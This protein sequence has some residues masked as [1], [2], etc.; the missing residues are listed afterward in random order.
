MMAKARPIDCTPPR[1][2]SAGSRALAARG[3]AAVARPALV[4][5]FDRVATG[6]AFHLIKAGRYH[7]AFSIGK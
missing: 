4:F 5:G 6:L 2:R 7:L 1:A 3:R